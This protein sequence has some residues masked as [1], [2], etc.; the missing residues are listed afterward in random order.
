MKPSRA[1]IVL[2]VFLFFC[3]PH[4][5]FAA[6]IVPDAQNLSPKERVDFASRRL[7]GRALRPRGD[8]AKDDV[9]ADQLVKIYNSITAAYD[10]LG[11][12]EGVATKR[13]QVNLE[14]A[15][16]LD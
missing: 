3:G 9:L 15:K 13:H 16:E 5:L 4:K 2:Y 6:A 12:S 10:E 14:W 7:A 11:T 8:A 1:V